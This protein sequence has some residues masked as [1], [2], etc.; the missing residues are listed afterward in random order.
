[1]RRGGF[2]IWDL[3]YDVLD[4]GFWIWDLGT[5]I[6]D[7]GFGILLVLVLLEVLHRVVRHHVFLKPLRRLEGRQ[8]PVGRA[9]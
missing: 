4:L 2:G 1:M 5:W 7:L 8:S 6:W 9:G 3:E